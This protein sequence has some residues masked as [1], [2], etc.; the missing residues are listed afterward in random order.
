MRRVLINLCGL[1]VINKRGGKFLNRLAAQVSN[2]RQLKFGV[3]FPKQRVGIFPLAIS[4]RI[5]LLKL[6]CFQIAGHPAFDSLNR[7][8]VGL[9]QLSIVSK[10]FGIYVECIYTATY[11]I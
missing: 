2:C 9:P 11:F 5:F 8:T 10:S 6:I 1:M 7:F 4:P 3:A